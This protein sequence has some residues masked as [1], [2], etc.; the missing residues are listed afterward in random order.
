MTNASLL[1][2]VA[3]GNRAEV[4]GC[5][6]M[7]DDVNA[8]NSNGETAL[9]LACVGGHRDCV[10]YLLTVGADINLKSSSQT[11]ALI[12]ATKQNF[13]SIVELLVEAGADM[14]VTDDE[15][16]TAVHYAA[17]RQKPKNEESSCLLLLLQAGADANTLSLSGGTPLVAAV[18]NNLQDNLRMLVK[19][20]VDVNSVSCFCPTL[21]LAVLSGSAKMVNELI[22]AGADLNQ[23]DLTSGAYTAL[24]VACAQQI[25]ETFMALLNAGADINIAKSQALC[26]EKH[27]IEHRHWSTLA[28]CIHQMRLNAKAATQVHLFYV[29]LAGVTPDDVKSAEDCQFLTGMSN[30]ASNGHEFPNTLLQ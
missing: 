9:I 12:A 23:K 3:T 13:P 7:G 11:T 30:C 17:A 26:R 29:S 28:Y 20:G 10:A 24:D 1:E 6:E 18:G 15:G 19:F 2:V 21:T 8:R 16:L 27:D 5:V 4:Q 14:M 25:N 22:W